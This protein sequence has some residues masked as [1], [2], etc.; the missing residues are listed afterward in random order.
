LERNDIPTEILL[1]CPKLVDAESPEQIQYYL[2][3]YKE[4][5]EAVDKDI[6]KEEEIESIFED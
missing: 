2:D 6:A 3:L 1:K 5:I 4:A